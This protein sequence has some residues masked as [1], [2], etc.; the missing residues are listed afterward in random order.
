M[1]RRIALALV[2]CLP[3]LALTVGARPSIAATSGN[4][5]ENARVVGQLTPTGRLNIRSFSF[6]ISVPQIRPW[7]PVAAARSA[8][9]P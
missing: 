4:R 7:P 3:V 1:N 5:A 8:R 6:G 2:L 9:R